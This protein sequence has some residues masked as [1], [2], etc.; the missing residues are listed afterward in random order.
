MLKSVMLRMK[1]S[2]ICLLIG[3]KEAENG[4]A[5]IRLRTGKQMNGL[6]TDEAVKFVLD[7]IDSKEDI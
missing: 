6:S 1:K 4:G 3:E 2:L 7:K 5:S